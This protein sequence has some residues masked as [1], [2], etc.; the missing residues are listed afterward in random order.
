M[1]D[2]H[3]VFVGAALGLIGS[4][5][6]AFATAR[7]AAR[8]NLV[9]WS[10]W[11][12]APL[13]GFFAQLSSGVGPQS[14]LTLAAGLGPLIVVLSA[15]LTAHSRV[16]VGLFDLGCA[17]VAL[18]ALV[19][20]FGLGQ[21]SLAVVAAASADAVAALPTIRKAWS[22]PESENLLF[23]V[24]VCLGAVI[25]LLTIDSWEPESW[26]FAVYIVALTTLLTA[27]ISGR[28]GLSRR[29]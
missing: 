21:A 16:R 18:I 22:D 9:T 20:W 23:Y 11:A 10:L 13:I 5:R 14:A 26:V 7:G 28:R 2:P 1:L 8:P 19:I 25:T 6:Y 17:A 27:I 24:L 15:L 3:W 4:L 29:A 12:A